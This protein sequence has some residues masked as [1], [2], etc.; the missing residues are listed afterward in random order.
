M[1]GTEKTKSLKQVSLEKASHAL[2][3]WFEQIRTLFDEPV[4][5]LLTRGEGVDVIL[6]Y[7]TSKFK[8]GFQIH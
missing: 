2:Q 8:F 1:E 4:N 5:I 3:Y 7:M 6:D